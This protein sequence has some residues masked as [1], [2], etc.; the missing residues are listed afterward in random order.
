M[1]LYSRQADALH[2]DVNG[3]LIIMS[4]E[5]F[6]YFSLDGVA[7][8]IWELLEPGAISAES[9]TR[10]LVAEFDVD[11]ETCFEA[12]SSFLAQATQNGIVVES[13]EPPL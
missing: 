9:L 5:S 11:E 2:A 4:A 6:D 12:V 13:T 10:T 1:T 7:P 8:R 3:D